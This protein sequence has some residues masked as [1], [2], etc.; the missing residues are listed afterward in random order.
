MHSLKEGVSNVVKN[1]SLGRPANVKKQKGK[2]KQLAPIKVDTI[3]QAIADIA[4]GKIVIVA[5]DPDR[6][7]EVDFIVSAQNI[8]P[9]T[10]ATLIRHGTGVICAAMSGAECDRLDLPPMREKNEDF[11][12]TAYTVSC[13]GRQHHGISTGISAADRAKT[14]SLLAEPHSTPGDLSRPGH[15]FPLR[16]VPGGTLQRGGHTEAGVDLT[17]LA[18]LPPVAAIVEVMHDDGTMVRLHEVSQF[19]KQHN[20]PKMS[21]ITIADLKKYREALNDTQLIAKVTPSVE[22][23]GPA[24]LPTAHGTF[25]IY[26]WRDGRNEHVALVMGTVKG[27]KSVLVRLHSEC[28]TGDAFGSLRCDCGP[29]LS[30][31]IEAIGRAG[32]GIIIYL[33]G[34]EGRGIGIFNKIAAYGLQDNGLDTFAAN[35]ALGLAEDA[36]D[37]SAAAQILQDLGV[38]SIQLLTNNPH[39]PDSLRQHN[40]KITKMIPLVTPRNPFNDKYLSA[41]AA[42]GHV[43]LM[44]TEVAV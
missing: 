21:V 27:A 6:E 13:D 3:E 25:Q 11:K 8:Q 2:A 42:R 12:Q 26:S 35:V 19:L 36:R 20:L 18:G 23:V 24:K 44:K 32:K 33:N 30:A 22:R 14:L 43:A 15:I 34:H 4:A 28:L 5:D 37:Y 40:I 7:N 38:Q 41:K 39:K 1:K 29:Q 10:V 9:E 16:A 17:T 31:A